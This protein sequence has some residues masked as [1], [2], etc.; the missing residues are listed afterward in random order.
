MKIFP[1]ASLFFLLFFLLF[2]GVA[3]AT[4]VTETS[5]QNYINQKIQQGGTIHLP[6]ETYVLT[7]SIILKSDIILE[8]E[9][10]TIITIPDHAAWPVWKPLVSGTGIRNITIRNL[11]F[12]ANSGGNSETPHGAGFYNCIHVTDCEDVKVYNCTLHD[13]LGD[14]LRTK[15]SRNIKFYNNCAYQLGHEGFF[16]I[17]SQGIECFNNRITTRTNSALRVWNSANV[18]FHDNIIDAQLDAQG[19]NPGIQI[20]DSKGSVNKV[21]IYN[22]VLIRTWGAGIWLVAYDAGTSNNQGVSIHHNLFYA[23]GHS[24]NIPYTGGV[25]NDGFKGTRIYNNVFDGALNNAFRNQAGGQGT[26]IKDNVFT[27]TAQHA[28][29]SQ[30]GTG[31]GIADLAE[32]GIFITNNSFY[33]NENGNLYQ[34]NSLNDDLADPKTHQTSSGWTWTGS[35]W[36]CES[37]KPIELGNIPL[38]TKIKLTII[39]TALHIKQFFGDILLTC[40]L[41]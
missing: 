12:D 9:P 39:K 5:D 37:V 31:Y 15:T 21:E 10:G 7:D 16:G 38:I 13:S 30:A 23:V 33:N 40:L 2:S 25:V 17:E 26:I 35:T 19:G 41:I 14:G 28:V 29:I 18:K 6:A 20:E 4:E 1:A 32:A 22:N 36:T 3:E 11:E 24:Y 27:N 8:G 34:A